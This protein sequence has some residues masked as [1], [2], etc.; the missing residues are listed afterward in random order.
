[1]SARNVPVAFSAPARRDIRDALLDTQRRWGEVQRRQFRQRID[2]ALEALIA[3]PELS[4]PRDELF[5]GCRSFPVGQHL[6]HYRRRADA[7]GIDVAR[8]LD[9]HQD[10]T[11][12]V[13]EPLVPQ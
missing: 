9:A 13:S 8:V 11:G 1:M 4:R 12:A 5:P 7:T 3:N 2:R 6:I 10:E